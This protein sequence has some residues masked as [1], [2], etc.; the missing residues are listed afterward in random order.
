MYNFRNFFLD[1]KLKL[2]NKKIGINGYVI[3]VFKYKI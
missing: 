1:F 2:N 3:N